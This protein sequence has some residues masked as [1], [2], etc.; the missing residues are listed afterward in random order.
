LDFEELRRKAES[1]LPAPAYPYAAGIPQPMARL[2]EKRIF[3]TST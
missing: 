3:S 2:P 1:A